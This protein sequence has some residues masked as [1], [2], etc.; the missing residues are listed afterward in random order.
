MTDFIIAGER[1]AGTTTL[2]NL[3]KNAEGVSM[4]GES[5]N[6]FFI[7]A[8]LSSNPKIRIE[9]SKWEENNNRDEYLESRE[10]YRK[11]Q[12]DLLGEKCSD[13]LF[14]P[15][16]H[17]R[18]RSYIPDVKLIISLRNPVDRA[19]SH[20]WHEVAKKR[21]SLSFERSLKA[22]PNRKDPYS[23]YNLSYLAR[24]DYHASLKKL[25]EVFPKQSVHIVILENLEEDLEGEMK[26]LANFIGLSEESLLTVPVPHINKNWALTNRYWT[27]ALRLN[28]FLSKYD[29]ALD[30]ILQRILPPNENNNRYKIRRIKEKLLWPFKKPASKDKMSSKTRQKLRGHFEQSISDLE[31]LLSIDLS[32]WRYDK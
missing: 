5:D 8:G 2:Y 19:W 24:G 32:I 27:N 17:L 7:D 18:I 12:S 23:Y 28:Y 15:H 29:R 10:K 6:S 30:M 14:W 31:K 21:E 16:S 11:S 4:F 9:N 3:L 13:I 26:R 20:Y 25:F 22:E 1:R